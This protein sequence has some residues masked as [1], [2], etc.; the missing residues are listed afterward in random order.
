MSMIEWSD[1]YSVG[2][3]SID[4]QHKQLI[5]LINKLNQAMAEGESTSVVADI[6][7]GLTEY[8]RFHFSFEEELLNQYD[9]PLT[10]DHQQEHARLIDRVEQFNFDFTQDPGGSISLELMHFLTNWLVSHIQG[11]DRDY[12]EFLIAKGVS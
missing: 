2:I 7:K 4:E 9:Y 1:I 3:P 11:S 5:A 6:L 10:K 8:T 12:S